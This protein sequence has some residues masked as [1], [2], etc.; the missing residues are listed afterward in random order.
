MASPIGDVTRL[1]RHAMIDIVTHPTGGQNSYCARMH[2][3][4]FLVASAGVVATAFV[5]ACNSSVSTSAPPKTPDETAPAIE[6]ASSTTTGAHAPATTGSTD[7][8]PPGLSSTTTSTSMSSAT[9][10]ESVTITATS[11]SAT[12]PPSAATATIPAD[13]DALAKTLQ[14]RVVLPSDATYDVVRLLQCKAFDSIRP[15]AIVSVASADDVARTIAFARAHQQTFAVRSGG[16]S[17]GGWSTGDGL[18]IDTR[19]MAAVGTV[20]SNGAVT[21][22]PGA[23]LIDV[24]TGLASQNATISAG[25]CA[26]VGFGGMALGG[27]HG[28]TSRAFGLTID[29]IRSVEIVTADGAV[30]HCDEATDSDLFWACRGGGGSFGVVTQFTVAS[31]PV[32]RE[33]TTFSMSYA[34]QKAGA[35]LTIWMDLLGSLPTATA[36]IARLQSGP[37]MALGVAGLHLGSVSSATSL[38]APLLGLADGH[39]ITERSFTD[40]LLLEAGCLQASVAACHSSATSPRGTLARQHP[41]AASSHYVNSPLTET[42]I[43]TAINRIQD[44]DGSLLATIQFDLEAGAIADVAADATAFVHR[45][46]TCSAQY[47]ASYSTGDGTTARSWIRATHEALAPFSNGESYQNYADVE[48]ADWPQAYYGSNLD[49][50]KQ[51]KRT[52]DPDNVFSFPQS[53]PLS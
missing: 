15:A 40:A 3:R 9:P 28:L 49:R 36:I 48:L 4:Q 45:G 6:P 23:Q 7:T 30:H 26:T 37:T 39:R 35:A 11:Q 8:V 29:A 19:A 34:W 33:V 47:A 20:S 53:I 2:R 14:G 24:Y 12:T 50:L 18:V 27:G 5:T 31:H 25:S 42:A 32:P 13:L 22:G 38:L 52:Y 51:I 21:I 1:L 10:T 44:H 46:A 16:H 41:F 17:Y 43:T